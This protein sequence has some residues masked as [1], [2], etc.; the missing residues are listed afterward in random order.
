MNNFV[1]INCWNN[2][3]KEYDRSVV[4]SLNAIASI[5]PAY[6][7]TST[8]VVFNKDAFIVNL[9]CAARGL[10]GGHE[11]EQIEKATYEKLCAAMGVVN[12]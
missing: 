3:S 6:K 4:V 10:N 2:V 7:C 11:R 1:R 9:T 8:Q 12:L 5:E